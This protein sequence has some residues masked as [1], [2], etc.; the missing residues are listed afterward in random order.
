[1]PTVDV[2]ADNAGE[3]RWRLTADNGQ[4]IAV[5]GEGYVK[6]SHAERMAEQISGLPPA[7]DDTPPQATRPADLKE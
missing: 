4:I 6:R 3:W 2:Y 5:S 7:A 1:M